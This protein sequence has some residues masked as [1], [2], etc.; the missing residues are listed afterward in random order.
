V[1]AS[2]NPSQGIIQL[3]TVHFISAPVLTVRQSNSPTLEL[4][5][6]SFLTQKGH[7]IL[8][9]TL[10]P[11]PSKTRTLGTHDHQEDL[12]TSIWGKGRAGI[13]MGWGGG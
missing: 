6:F 7:D 8:R 5:F 10:L 4:G 11:L 12:D 2:G 3:R 9:V 13:G 1:A